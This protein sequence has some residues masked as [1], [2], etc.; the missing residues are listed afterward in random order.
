MDERLVISSGSDYDPAEQSDVESE[1]S[2][3]LEEE[4]FSNIDKGE[5]S[6]RSG[7]EENDEAGEGEG[8]KKA[9]WE[10]EAG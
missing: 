2:V 5:C 4:N 9:V 3:S 6:T 8:C 10:E 1:G 7:D